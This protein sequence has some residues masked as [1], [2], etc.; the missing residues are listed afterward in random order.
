MKEHLHLEQKRG[1][2]LPPNTPVIGI[3]GQIACGKDTIAR[4]LQDEFNFD[5]FPYSQVLESLLEA[6][7]EIKPIPREKRW[8]MRRELVA[9][10]GSGAHTRLLWDSILAFNAI[11]DQSVSGVILNGP[12]PIEEALELK[13]LPNSTLIG[14]YCPTEVRY[15]RLVS[16]SRAGDAFTRE[17]FER[18]DL[19]E[20]QEMREMFSSGV[21]DVVFSNEGAA[22]DIKPIIVN[23]IRQRYSTN[24]AKTAKK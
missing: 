23:F 22:E 2:E 20:H 7:G 9:K 10:E 5:H 6:R 18:L 8:E 16:R 17:D 3:F 21:A 19:A 24:Q 4:I 1:M 12:R 11:S 13:K 14:I 15:K